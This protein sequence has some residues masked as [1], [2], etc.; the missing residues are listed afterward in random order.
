[1]VCRICV[2]CRVTKN[3]IFVQISGKSHEESYFVYVFVCVA[4]AECMRTDE[5]K[6]RTGGYE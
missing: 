5:G 1:M 4:L 6:E 2:I 3:C